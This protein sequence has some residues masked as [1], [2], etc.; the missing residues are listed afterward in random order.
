MKYI[1]AITL[2]I[3][4]ILSANGQQAD[5]NLVELSN[6]QYPEGC[7]DIWGY[8]DG[9]GTEY[10]ILGTREATA[11][12]SLEDPE[13]PIQRAYIPGVRSTW[14]DIKTW[15]NYAYV[16]ADVGD[17]GLLIID[18]ANAP[19][20]ITHRF[21]NIP[22][23]YNGG[24][25]QILKCHNVYI[26]E[27][28][29]MYLSGCNTGSNGVMMFDLTE[30]PEN[31]KF[32]GAESAAYSHDN[33]ARGDT[34]WSS[35]L[36]QGFSVWDVSDKANPVEL[37]RQRTSSNFAHNGWFSDDNNYFFTT[38][39]RPNAYLDAYDVSNMNDIK[40]LDFYRPKATENRGV[41]PHNTHFHNG[42]LVTSWYTDGV[43]I[44][45]G[46]KPDNLIEVG[47]FDS[48]A[49]PDGGFNGCW[50]AYPYLPSGLLL[51]NDIQTGLY[52][53]EPTYQ[54]ACY[55][56]GLVTDEVTTDPIQ[57][58]SVTIESSF[59][60]E[61][62]T[63]FTGEYKSG[64]PDAGMYEVTFSHPDYIDTTVE[65]SLE[66]G[67]VTIQ[68]MVMRNRPIYTVT[69]LV[70][71]A[72][73][74]APVANAKL[75][76]ANDFD[77]YTDE[78]N[79]SGIF[80]LP[81]FQDMTDPTYTVVAGSWG[82]EH[83]VLEDE[84]IDGNVQFT[85]ELEKGYQDDFIFD[86]GWTENG[87]APRGKWERGV[88]NGTSVNGAVANPDAD[89]ISDIGISCFVTGNA[90]TGG[91]GDD[92]VD[93]GFTILSSPVMDL[94]NYVE[95]V[96]SYRSWFFNGSRPNPNDSFLVTITN[97]L[98]E[99][100]LE[101]IY[102]SGS[103]WRDSSVFK[104]ADIIDLTDSMRIKAQVSDDAADGHIS[105]GGFDEFRVEDKFSTSVDIVSH[106]DW[107]IRPT[108]T[109]TTFEVIWNEDQEAQWVIID[110]Y[111]RNIMAGELSTGR[112]TVDVTS[113]KSGVYFIQLLTTAGNKDV[114][115]LVIE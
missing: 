101:V 39:E 45:D 63:D 90:A 21:L 46:N 78:A 47:S 38:D 113:L 22:F 72:V 82:Y 31:P 109:N 50:G 44:V 10:A 6:V 57:D 8:V 18:M 37:A 59:L 81:I 42:Y 92:D 11:I 35:D 14:R 68:N 61:E 103:S 77:S 4:T 89:V 56:E 23:T 105:E 17:D 26:D 70:I 83:K 79:A 12:L 108:I 9:E 87:T 66:N 75:S 91:A 36:S 102:E 88:P 33:V 15:E 114:R 73:T 60:N 30:D 69:G 52:V 25:E 41:I 55:L 106:L 34:L 3:V 99:V 86:L 49:G 96:L 107:D 5:F 24:Q 110:S 58:V 32:L 111:G 94:T 53:L 93:D 27:K 74:K 62:V 54:R 7:N 51:I 80:N 112:E 28:G 2:L 43:K 16:I 19:D 71:D 1:S 29:V 104:L 97:G 95:P 67:E 48:Y 65:V 84:V 85:I 20:T 100:K 40:F 64:L 98:E 76:F 115:A 13:N